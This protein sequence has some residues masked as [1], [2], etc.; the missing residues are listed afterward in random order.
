MGDGARLATFAVLNDVADALREHRSL[1]RDCARAVMDELLSGRASA[2]DVAAVLLGLRDKGVDAI[3]L[4]GLLDGVRAAAV[5]VELPSDVARRAIDIVGTGGDHSNSVNVSTMASFVVAGAGVP[6][7]KHGNRAATS[8]C[9]TADVLEALGARIELSAR[10]VVEC[11]QRSGVG[12]CFAPAFHPA[13]RHV[14]P[15]R[16]SLGVP[17]VFNVL[18]PL[19]NPANVAYMLV[20]VADPAVRA[21]MAE[22]LVARGVAAAWLVHGAGGMDELSLAGVNSIVA[23]GHDA[24]GVESSCDPVALG[25]APAPTSE[26]RGGDPAHNAAIVRRVFAGEVGE[27]RAIRDTVVL[28]AAAALRVAGVQASWPDAIAAARESI[29]GG[30]AAQRLASFIATSNTLAT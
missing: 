20:G 21:N 7:C 24:A 19:A 30:A 16:R 11:V 18:G 1:T 15:V 8:K 23:V 5:Q 9:G 29:D 2:D 28:N 25:F 22:A 4:T 17:T 13:F 27:L 12:F 26:L 10:A 6:V 3:E 14:G